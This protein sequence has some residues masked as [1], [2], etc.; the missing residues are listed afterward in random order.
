MSFKFLYLTMKYILKFSFLSFSLIFLFNA[1]NPDKSTKADEIQR[2]NDPWVFRSVLDQKPRMVTLALHENLW[3]SYSAEKGALYK[4]WKG[5]VDFD[6]AVYTTAHGPQP[7]TTGDAYILNEYEEPWVIIENEKEF[8]PQ[9][10]YKGH[11][12]INGHAELMYTLQW[13]GKSVNVNEQ[14]E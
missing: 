9:V 8:K 4:V 13:N 3:A 7:I 14:P 6:G 1:C 11:R 2:P 12:Y 5:M 10:S